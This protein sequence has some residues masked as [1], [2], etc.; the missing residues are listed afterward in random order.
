MAGFW[1]LFNLPVDREHVQM[2]AK[3]ARIERQA[4]RIADRRRRKI[5]LELARRGAVT[6]PVRITI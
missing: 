4:V 2:L 5:L 3:L 1:S 6:A